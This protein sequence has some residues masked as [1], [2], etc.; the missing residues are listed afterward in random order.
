MAPPCLID[1]TT[2]VTGNIMKKL[3]LASAAIVAFAAPAFAADLPARTYTKAPAYT[4]PAVVYNWTGFYIGGHVGGAFGGSSLESS[5]ARFL[6]GVQGGFDYQFSSHWV[7]GA[8]DR[9]S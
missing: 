8:G 1:V 2:T 5:D 7:L 4:A 6:G 9:Y 3:L